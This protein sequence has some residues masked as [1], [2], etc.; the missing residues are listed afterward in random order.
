MKQLKHFNDK[1]TE[2]HKLIVLSTISNLN[3]INL[4]K[5]Q[6]TN[7]SFIVKTIK[8]LEENTGVNLYEFKLSNVIL[9]MVPKG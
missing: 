9:Y 4:K 6:R 3:K 5:G 1:N 8:L 2:K 7:Y